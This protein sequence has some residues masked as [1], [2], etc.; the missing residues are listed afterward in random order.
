MLSVFASPSKYIQGK[1]VIK[2]GIH[3]IKALGERALILSDDMVYDIVGKNLEK[4]L[5]EQ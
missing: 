2:S 1:D 5:I 3:Y 4:N